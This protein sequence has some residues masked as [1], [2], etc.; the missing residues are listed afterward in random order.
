M[1]LTNYIFCCLLYGFSG[2]LNG[3]ELRFDGLC[4]LED[5]QHTDMIRF[6]HKDEKTIIGSEIYRCKH[7]NG[8]ENPEFVA[9]Y[10]PGWAA[11]YRVPQGGDLVEEHLEASE[12]KALQMYLATL[13]VE[14]EKE[15]REREKMNV[16]L[17]E[18]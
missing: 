4:Y 3:M 12:R 6:F 5:G 2:V 10:W 8:P 11:V 18:E 1:K 17:S 15:L 16:R 9:T 13:I 14:R 7:P